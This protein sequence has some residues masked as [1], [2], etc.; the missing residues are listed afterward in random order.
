MRTWIALLL[1]ISGLI[2]SGLVW[3]FPFRGLRTGEI[4]IFRHPDELFYACRLNETLGQPWNVSVWPVV[5]RDK[6]W[7]ANPHIHWS[8]WPVVRVAEVLGIHDGNRLL[9]FFRWFTRVLLAVAGI[10]VVREILLGLEIERRLVV[11]CSVLLGGYLAMEPGLAHIKPF[12]GNLIGKGKNDSFVGFD[13]PVSPSSD[14]LFFTAAIW[15]GLRSIRHPFASR[16]EQVLRGF[17]IS[18]LLL[19]SPWYPFTFAI[20]AAVVLGT[21][22]L[23]S[24]DRRAA[25]KAFLLW[26]LKAGPWLA[27]GSLPVVTFCLIKAHALAVLGVTKEFLDRSGCHPT[28]QLDF[29][30]FTR[31]SLMLIALVMCG[32]IAWTW[33]RKKSRWLALP[34]LWIVIAFVC[35]NH[36]VFL[37]MSLLNGHFEPPL[38]ILLGLAIITTAMWLFRGRPFIAAL[39][40]C[41]LG[42]VCLAAVA[43]KSE[44]DLQITFQQ[45]PEFEPIL[46]ATF[47]SASQLIASV[48]LRGKNV[49]FIAPDSIELPIR[50]LTGWRPI[51]S[52]YLLMYPYSD[53]ELWRSY[54]RYSALTGCPVDENF[55]MT[56][57]PSSPEDVIDNSGWFYGLPPGVKPPPVWV[58][59]ARRK[60]LPIV[61]QAATAELTKPLYYGGPLPL[62]VIR[63]PEWPLPDSDRDADKRV[64]ADRWEAWEWNTPFTINGVK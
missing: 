58:A 4:P 20:A 16:T 52:F 64:T 9:H 37:G 14:I 1:L 62:V 36:A 8:A 6:P 10:C 15:A 28:R 27:L 41:C 23:C 45:R 11:P 24:L 34:L 60:Y 59:S 43:K 44:R 49:A 12:L 42:L 63:R 48:D 35:F 13:R 17:V 38:G 26:L 47:S 33:D 46:P 54:V 29:L 31:S 21:S 7:Y 61:R 19:L 53:E 22:L 2:V 39:A 51:H 40:L 3:P 32:I 18:T 25:W 55:S 30:L 50:F 56:P 57:F 5:T